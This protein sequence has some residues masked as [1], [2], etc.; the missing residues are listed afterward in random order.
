MNSRVRLAKSCGAGS[1]G[2]GSVQGA[3][4]GA[5]REMRNRICFLYEKRVRIVCTTEKE[6]RFDFFYTKQ[7]SHHLLPAASFYYITSISIRMVPGFEA[8][9]LNR[10]IDKSGYNRVLL[11]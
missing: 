10:N 6:R 5:K 4:G 8:R 2:G 3:A 1:G 7:R 9:G 11:L